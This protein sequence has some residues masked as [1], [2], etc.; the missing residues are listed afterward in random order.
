MR[1]EHSHQAAFAD[2]AF[3]AGATTVHRSGE[4]SLWLGR[5]LGV[6]VLYLATAKLGFLM[7][8]HP[9]N[10]TAVWPPSGIALAALHRQLIVIATQIA[11]SAISRQQREQKIRA[12]LDDLLCW[13]KAMLG[14]AGRVMALKT[15]FNE[16]HAAQGP[17]AR[18]PSQSTP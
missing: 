17:P 16:L 11:A 18:S 3:P 8:I 4:R 10:V 2:A 1:D 7:A 5:G 6:A 9:G 15:E 14:R 12:P 13:R